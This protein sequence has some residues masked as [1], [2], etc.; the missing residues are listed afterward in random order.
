MGR[1]RPWKRRSVEIPQKARDSHF[2]TAPTT[3]DVLQRPCPK[4]QTRRKSHYPWTKNGG[5]VTGYPN[6]IGRNRPFA[7]GSEVVGWVGSLTNAS[8]SV[9]SRCDGSQP[10]GI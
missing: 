8:P 2:P 1:D 5:Q 6:S 9:A 4:T 10:D 7:Q 3:A